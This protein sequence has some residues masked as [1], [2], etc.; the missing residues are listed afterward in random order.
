MPS[1]MEAEMKNAKESTLKKMAAP[2][3]K[4]PLHN[5]PDATGNNVHSQEAKSFPS[6]RNCRECGAMDAQESEELELLSARK[7]EFGFGPDMACMPDSEKCGLLAFLRRIV[8]LDVL[9]ASPLPH[10]NRGSS[11]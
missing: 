9:M 5:N 4:L 7:S 11:C 2:A 10:N 6:L 3:K 8:A 1:L